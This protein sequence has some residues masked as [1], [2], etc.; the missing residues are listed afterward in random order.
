MKSGTGWFV[1]VLLHC[2]SPRWGQMCICVWTGEL[3]TTLGLFLAAGPD[4][5]VSREGK[6]AEL[7]QVSVSFALVFLEVSSALLHGAVQQERPLSLSFELQ[8]WG[9]IMGSLTLCQQ[10]LHGISFHSHHDLFWIFRWY[11]EGLS[12]VF[13]SLCFC[14]E[15]VCHTTA[16]FCLQLNQMLVTLQSQ[17]FFPVI[18]LKC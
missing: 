11:A 14:F 2:L 5:S 9:N 10:T 12:K 15:G 1:V 16:R 3:T 13:F 6:G 18:F 7:F 4:D 17:C 8:L